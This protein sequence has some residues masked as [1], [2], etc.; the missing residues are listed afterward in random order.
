MIICGLMRNKANGNISMLCIFHSKIH[1]LFYLYLVS[2]H[3]ITEYDKLCYP[4]NY[5]LHISQERW[6]ISKKLWIITFIFKWTCSDSLTNY[7]ELPLSSRRNVKAN[8]NSSSEEMIKILLVSKYFLLQAI[9]NLLFLECT[10]TINS[11]CL[12]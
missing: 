11:C 8:I 6:M 1:I 7:G 5:I 2:F 10:I 9:W 12:L 3:P 4:T